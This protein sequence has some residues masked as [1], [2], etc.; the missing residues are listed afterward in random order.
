[1][2]PLTIVFNSP[3]P[4]SP[5]KTTQE[6]ILQAVELMDDS[7]RGA[8]IVIEG[9]PYRDMPEDGWDRT[10]C[11]DGKTMA[12]KQIEKSNGVGIGELTLLSEEKATR[13]KTWILPDGTSFTK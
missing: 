3:L 7:P 2:I 10:I 1:M 8:N 4:K 9:V 12:W 6:L 11:E 13:D 5:M